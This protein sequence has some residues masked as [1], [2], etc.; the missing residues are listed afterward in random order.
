VSRLRQSLQ[1]HTP[2]HSKQPCHDC[3]RDPGSQ[4]DSCWVGG[5][6]PALFFLSFQALLSSCPQVSDHPLPSCGA[7]PLSLPLPNPTSPLSTLLIPPT[8]VSLGPPSLTPP[9]P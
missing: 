2:P 3:K 7:G 5:P 8:P 6:F 9:F 1:L 4:V